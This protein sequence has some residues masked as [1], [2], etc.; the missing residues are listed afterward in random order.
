VGRSLGYNA[1]P[2]STGPW[3]Q[4]PVEQ[5]K[6]GKKFTKNSLYVRKFV[7]EHLKSYAISVIS[8]D[9]TYQAIKVKLIC[10]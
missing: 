4:S 2:A 7:H 9:Q 1:C 3:G 5:K 8:A 10:K 6:K